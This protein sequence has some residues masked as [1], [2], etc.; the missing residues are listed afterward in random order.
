MLSRASATF[1]SMLFN[2][3][4][5]SLWVDGA[6]RDELCMTDQISGEW[7]THLIGLPATISP[8]NLQA[9][10]ENIFR[11]NFNPEFGVHNATAPKRGASLLALNNL[12]AGGLC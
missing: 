5:Y 7:F 3:D 11:H 6:T 1:D 4:Y 10:I 9:A 12:Q 2:G 8:K